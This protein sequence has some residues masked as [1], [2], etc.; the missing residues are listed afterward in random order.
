MPRPTRSLR[1]LLLPLVL[2]ACACPGA[3]IARPYAD[4]GAD[5]VV[6]YLTSL[7]QR[8]HTL[9][10][11]TLSDARIGNDRAN[12]TVYILATWGGRL[13]YQAMNP[14]G[15]ALAADLAS[16]GTEFCFIDANKNCGECGPATP[17]NVGQ[18]LQVAMEPDD[19]VTMMFGGT[20][21]LAGA[22]AALR[23]DASEG[24]EVLD[25]EAEDGTKQRIVLDGVDHRWD[26]L[27]S[28][29]TNPDGKRAFRIR[30]KDFHVVKSLSG[31][32]VRVP[33][34]SFFEQPGNDA[35]IR[36]KEQEI[37]VELP[38]DKFHMDV[39]AGLATCS[40]QKPAPAAAGKAH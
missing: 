23:W 28:E 39:P 4:P 7:R 30:H 40:Q 20:P 14:G 29:V 26:V 35:L 19:V 2:V 38:G 16:D 33:G 32:P 34:K 11:E 18:L 9:R 27:Q 8:V 24:H 5:Q 22:T 36:W 37:D 21:V 1:F 15:G 13:R 25:L 12:I 17:Q 31:Q 10:A 6:A 3:R